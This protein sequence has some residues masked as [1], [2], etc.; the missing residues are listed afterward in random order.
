MQYRPKTVSEILENFWDREEP[1]KIAKSHRPTG[2]RMTRRILEEYQDGLEK[3]KTI[4]QIVDEYWETHEKPQEPD[5][6]QAAEEPKV[7][8]EPKAPEEKPQVKEE[9]KVTDQVSDEPQALRER[10]E[11]SLLVFEHGRTYHNVTNFKSMS[12]TVHFYEFDS[13]WHGKITHVKIRLG[14][15]IEECVIKEGKE[16]S[17]PQAIA[18]FCSTLSV[19]TNSGSR[20]EFKNVRNL[21]E[22][23][24]ARIVEFDIDVDRKKR[25]QRMSGVIERYLEVP[26]ESSEE[27]R[28]SIPL[29]SFI[30]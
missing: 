10:T 14:I 12:K 24:S 20:E 30:D 21:T 23:K 4:S 1:G 26:E 15:M 28:K 2:Y 11:F 3:P 6:P 18:K 9:P 8:K 29:P 13:E 25:H 22:D 17:E 19:Y 5:K 7:V 16:P 27:E